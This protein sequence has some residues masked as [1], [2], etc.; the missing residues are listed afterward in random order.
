MSKLLRCA[1]LGVVALLLA[2]SAAAQDAAA[3]A[4]QIKKSANPDLIGA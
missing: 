1:S 2:G 4:D 3:L